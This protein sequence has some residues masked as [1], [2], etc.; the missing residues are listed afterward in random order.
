MAMHFLVRGQE[1]F[2]RGATV[3]ADERWQGPAEVHDDPS[4]SGV[5]F[6]TREERVSLAP[7]GKRGSKEGTQYGSFCYLCGDVSLD[8]AGM[9]DG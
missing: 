8:I 2:S 5:A 1:R 9:V 4:V 6:G 7:V 3:D